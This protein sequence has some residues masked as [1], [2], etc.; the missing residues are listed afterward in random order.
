MVGNIAPDAPLTVVADV[1]PVYK[2]PNDAARIVGS[3]SV[4]MQ[5]GSV[6]GVWAIASRPSLTRPLVLPLFIVDNSAVQPF[7]I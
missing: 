2:R 4:G 3:F 5:V 1:A 7:A 6:A